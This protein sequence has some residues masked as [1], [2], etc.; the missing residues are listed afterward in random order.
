MFRIVSLL[1][2]A[3]SRARLRHSCISPL[4]LA[5]RLNRRTVA[6]VLLK[7]GADVNAT[8]GH[9]ESLRYADRPTTA[10]YFALAHA[11]LETAEL[12]LREGASLSLDPVSPLLLALRHGY[13]HLVSLMLERGA[14]PNTRVPSYPATFPTAVALCMNNLH[15][16]KCLLDNGCDALSCFACAHGS[17][18]HPAAAAR[19]LTSNRSN[20]SD[21]HSDSVIPLSC[22]EATDRP[23]Q[24][25]ESK[26]KLALQAS[27]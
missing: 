21:R 7:T 27:L 15:M 13:A 22:S 24:V 26:Q 9:S 5:A 19:S 16:L 4:H 8:V 23:I 11:G 12:L 10:L 17:S 18:P 6:A 3:T 2:P 14:D 1:I 20:G 25:W